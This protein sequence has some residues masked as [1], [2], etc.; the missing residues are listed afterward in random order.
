MDGLGE[1]QGC[2]EGEVFPGGLFDF[3][4]EIWLMLCYD[5]YRNSAGKLDK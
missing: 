1:R 4:V 2:Q 5:K 3:P